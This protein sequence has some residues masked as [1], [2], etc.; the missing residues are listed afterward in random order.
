MRVT[1]RAYKVSAASS[2]PSARWTADLELR[3]V[4]H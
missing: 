2:T 1:V 4:F 3:P